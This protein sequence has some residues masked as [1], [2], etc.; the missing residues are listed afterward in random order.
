M[1]K[2]SLYLPPELA[3]RFQIRC[4]EVERDMSEVITELVGAWLEPTATPGAKPRSTR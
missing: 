4:F 1:R 3:K 2:V